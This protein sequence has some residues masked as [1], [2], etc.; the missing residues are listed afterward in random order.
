MKLK[1]TTEI[2]YHVNHDDFEECVRSAYGKDF[3]FKLD[4]SMPIPFRGIGYDE[5]EGDVH[6]MYAERGA[7]SEFEQNEL[8]R[9]L[10]HEYD[11]DLAGLCLSSIMLSDL[12][13]KGLLEPGRYIVSSRLMREYEDGQY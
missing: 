9:W 2:T 8:N 5:D 10:N 7:L 1:C 3:N 11:D 13:N 6:D 12:C 4:M